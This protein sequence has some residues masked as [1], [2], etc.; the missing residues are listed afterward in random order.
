MPVELRFELILESAD[1]LPR[2]NARLWL[3]L[4]SDW[5]LSDGEEI[6]LSSVDRASWIGVHRLDDRDSAEG[7]FFVLRFVAPRKTRWAFTAKAGDVLSY[8]TAEGLTTLEKKETLTGT[9]RRIADAPGGGSAAAG[10]DDPNPPEGLD[11]QAPPGRPAP[12][13]A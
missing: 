3:D 4:S 10:G 8:R 9:L 5:E 12:G 1:G 13:D 11:E 7:L 2:P 6:P